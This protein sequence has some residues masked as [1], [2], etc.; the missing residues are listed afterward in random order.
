MC[1]AKKKK[2]KK[3]KRNEHCADVSREKKTFFS[4]WQCHKKRMLML[5]HAEK[6]IGNTK[7]VES[8][9]DQE[10]IVSYD[11]N[12]KYLK[13]RSS[14]AKR[15]FSFLFF[16]SLNLTDQQIMTIRDKWQRKSPG[17]KWMGGHL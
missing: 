4:V 9:D 16:A 1:S 6:K 10:N 12:R 13:V 11:I 7:M 2:N 8:F 5:L 14:K 3:K 15:F 17:R